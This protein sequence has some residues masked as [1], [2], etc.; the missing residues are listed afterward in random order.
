MDSRLLP[1]F[2]EYYRHG[3]WPD[4]RGR[5]Y[6][7]AKLCEA[8]AC[9]HHYWVLYEERAAREQQQKAQQEIARDAEKAR[10]RTIRR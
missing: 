8:F 2:S 7:P 6:Q 10:S 5:F 1:F 9:M 4:G 3:I